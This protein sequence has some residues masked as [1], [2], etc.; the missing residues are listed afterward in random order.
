MK[1]EGKKRSNTWDYCP[2]LQHSDYVGYIFSQPTW[3]VNHSPII[4]SSSFECL[5]VIACKMYCMCH[6]DINNGAD[7]R[8]RKAVL[9]IM[10]QDD[11]GACKKY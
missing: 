3:L 6:L 2:N 4:W 9:T 10:Y 8:Q 5:S 7:L 1:W 11:F